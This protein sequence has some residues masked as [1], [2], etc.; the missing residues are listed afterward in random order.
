M[1]DLSAKADFFVYHQ[2]VTLL[3]IS[4]FPP[5]MIS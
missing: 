3:E 2:D 5:S 4:H 1:H